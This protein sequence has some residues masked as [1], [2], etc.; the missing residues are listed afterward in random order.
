MS[1]YVFN[2]I[3]FI[4]LYFSIIGLI[5]SCCT[6]KD[7]EAIIDSKIISFEGF[8]KQDLDTIKIYRYGLGSGFTMIIDS[9][10]KHI[11]LYNYYK[12]STYSTNVHFYFDEH[13]DYLIILPKISKTYKITN[14]ET[15][16]FKCNM[17]FPKSAQDYYTDMKSYCQD[18]KLFYSRYL[19]I[20]KN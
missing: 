16:N 6:K 18:G 3:K 2:K 5:T 13:Y 8:K 20:Y 19:T 1:I 4:L 15:E 9:T 11:E 12:D 17:C 10:I 7:C 14:L